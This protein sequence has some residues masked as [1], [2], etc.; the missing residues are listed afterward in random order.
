MENQLTIQSTKILTPHQKDALKAFDIYENDFIEIEYTPTAVGNVAERAI[1]TSQNAVKSIIE[2]AFFKEKIQE[3]YC[4]GEKTAL[5]LTELG[6]NV[7]VVADSSKKLAL[8]IV[9]QGDM[10]IDFYCGNIRRDELPNILGDNGVVVKER[11]VYHTKL[12]AHQVNPKI[13]GVLFFSPSAVRA[14]L[15]S[16]LAGDS[17][18]FCIGSST[19]RE[20]KSSFNKTVIA[21][22]PTIE[23]VIESVIKYFK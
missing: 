22:K 2:T 1:F 7:I 16:N 10:I 9:K 18:A 8:E 4:V 14:Y 3:V 13:D 6:K 21:E 5:L 17:V 20:V 12:K 19:E 15:M 11:V 23:S